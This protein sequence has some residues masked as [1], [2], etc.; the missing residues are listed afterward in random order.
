MAE[1]SPFGIEQFTKLITDGYDRK[2][3]LYP[4]L[5]LLMPIA[6]VIS[7]GLGPNLTPAKTVCGVV[8]SCGGSCCF[9]NLRVT[10]ASEKNG[11]C[12][13]SGEACHQSVFF[14]I[15]TAQWTQ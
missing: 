5:L 15:G 10:Q 2:A 6:V 7:C 9:H 14:V 12:S 3:R 1:S 13:K 11:T 4:G 8:A